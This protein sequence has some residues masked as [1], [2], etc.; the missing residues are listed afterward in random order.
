MMERQIIKGLI[1]GMVVFSSCYYDNAEEL[2]PSTECITDNMSLQNN[3][4]PILERNC[5]VCHSVAAGPGNGNVTLEGYSE[6]IK[7]VNSGQLVGAINHDSE[8]S[9]MPQNAPKLGTCDIQKIE[10]WVSDG[11]PDN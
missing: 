8:Y 7:Y 2:Y 9:P 3:I 10:S 1:F 4:E 11:A 5:Y 6:L